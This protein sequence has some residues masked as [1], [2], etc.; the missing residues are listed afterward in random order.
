M[1]NRSIL[2]IECAVAVTVLTAC[3]SSGSLSATGDASTEAAPVGS[4]DAG[5]ADAPQGPSEAA[6]ADAAPEGGL[7]GWRTSYSAPSADADGGLMEGTEMRALV[8]FNGAL[9]AG[10]G[11]WEDT[12]GFA[13]TSP[14]PGLPGAQVL[15]LDGPSAGWQIDLE[16]D[17]VVQTGPWAGQRA[18]Y[19]I[20]ALESLTMTTDSSGVALSPAVPLLA[21]TTWAHSSGLHVYVRSATNAQWV[22][23]VLGGAGSG[24]DEGRA[25]AVHVDSQTKISTA[26]TGSDIGI[27]SGVYD[28]ATDTIVWSQTSEPWT[29]EDGGAAD[30][31]SDAPPLDDGWRVMSFTDCDGSF[32]ATI[33]P[34]I[35]QRQDGPNPTWTKVYTYPFANPTAD[36]LNGTGGL[37]GIY[38][39]PNSSGSDSTLLVAAEGVPDVIKVDPHAGFTE[40][41]DEDVASLLTVRW[42]FPV[43]GALIAYNH[44]TPAID[45]VTQEHVLLIGFEAHVGPNVTPPVPVFP[46][47]PV[48]DD[49]GIVNFLATA[50]YLVRHADGSY[51]VYSMEDPT[52][53]QPP[54]RVSVR[55]LAISP[56]P[57]DQAA[58]VY[59][60]GF[61]CNNTP[62]HDTAWALKGPL[63]LALGH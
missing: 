6:A 37:R 57:E 16:L 19:A 31:G 60:G 54:P 25:F 56:F 17:D 29:V 46:T 22:E 21:A 43:A 26:F 18:A 7:T 39:L 27:F 13:S 20:A 44:F 34:A 23:S 45:P 8:A 35:Y 50:N 12:Q 61:D 15:R 9:Y 14:N 24:A 28:R 52:L 49:G 47:T 51:D 32:Y 36:F 2:C 40:T 5:L 58:V 11:Y 53:P 10:I 4:S 41:V 1:M 38:C 63:A 59:A 30:G 48:G 33:G 3:S 62:E 42:G 55:T